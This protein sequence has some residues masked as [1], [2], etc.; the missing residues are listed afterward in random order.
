ML[1]P[2]GVGGVAQVV[3][4]AQGLA[5][6]GPPRV[7]HRG[8]EDL[9]AVLLREHLVD[10]PGQ[11]RTGMGAAGC[12]IAPGYVLCEAVAAVREGARAEVDLWRAGSLR[13]DPRRRS[14]GDPDVP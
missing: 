6:G 12:C 7:A 5:E 4:Q 10:R 11:M 9:F 2:L 1:H 8:Q 14:T 13:Y 3:P